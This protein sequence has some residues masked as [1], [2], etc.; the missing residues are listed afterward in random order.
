MILTF[1]SSWNVA[2]TFAGK[3]P[4]GHTVEYE[5]EV[6]FYEHMS[7]TLCNEI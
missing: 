5:I 3:E 6:S 1:Q 4:Y 7:Q 2:D